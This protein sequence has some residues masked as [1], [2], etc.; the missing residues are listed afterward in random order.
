MTSKHFRTRVLLVDDEAAIRETTAAILENE[1][2]TVRVAGD[3]FA[4]LI[5]LRDTPPDVIISD[6]RMPDMSGFEFLAIVRRRFPNSPTIAISGEFVADNMVAGLLVDA[7]FQKGGYTPAELF[8]TIRRLISESPIRA[9]A[10]KPDKAPLWIPRRDTGYIVVVC[11]E[12]LRSF[13]VDD[14]STGGQVRD[15]DCPS[16]GTR[17]RYMV[18]PAVLKK[19][20]QMRK[21]AS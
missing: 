1:G 11:T 9:H 7:F 6:L 2:F 19:F 20:Q 13:P 8:A 10:P 17:V 14:S 5:A 21:S 15:T 18:D 4:A 3:G 16:C 12:C